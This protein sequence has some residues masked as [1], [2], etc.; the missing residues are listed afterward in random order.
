MTLGIKFHSRLIYDEKYIKT[1]VK[2][3]NDVVNTVFSDNEIQKERN[4]YICI[5]AINIDSVMKIDTK[6]T[7]LKFI[8]NSANIKKKK[9]KT[10][11]FY[12]CWIRSRFRWFRWF[13]WI[14]I[15][16]FICCGTFLNLSTSNTKSRYI[17]LNFKALLMVFE[18]ASK[19]TILCMHQGFINCHSQSF[20]IKYKINWLT[21]LYAMPEV[22]NTNK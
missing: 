7:T 21:K 19:E 12:S 16:V 13:G 11:R 14:W 20:F 5:A 9:E 4:H 8:Q 3:F 1:K 6:K 17:W 22:L 18:L 2:T 15:I 10:S